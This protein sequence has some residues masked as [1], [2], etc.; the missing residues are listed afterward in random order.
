M[1]REGE[2]GGGSVDRVR[3]RLIRRWN[4]FA[5]DNGGRMR[6]VKWL[7]VVRGNGQCRM[8]VMVLEC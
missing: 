7:C 6:S 5:L 1:K 8:M 2:F 3:W 4:L